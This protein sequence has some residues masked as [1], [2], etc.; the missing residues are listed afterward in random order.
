MRVHIPGLA[1]AFTEQ[2]FFDFGFGYIRAC[3]MDGRLLQG[4]A[5][6]VVDS[7]DG[8]QWKVGIWNGYIIEDLDA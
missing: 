3:F 1:E 2:P 5:Q 8:L 4:L 6:D 7:K